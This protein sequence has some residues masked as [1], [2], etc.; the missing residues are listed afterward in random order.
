MAFDKG[1]VFTGA[2]AR[3]SIQG[4]TIGYARNCSGRE[5]TQ[6]DRIKG[7]GKFRTLEHVPVDYDVSFTMGW[8]RLVGETLKK[9]GWFPKVGVSSEEHLTNIL[10]SGD[11]TVTIEDTKTNLVFMT[12]E[13]AVCTDRNFNIDAVGSVMENTN[14]LGV[15]M[16]DESDD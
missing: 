13:Q 9:N 5:A 2:R 3:L 10:A 11:L 1:R 15:I 12:L 16:R 8:T 4:I 7:L 6:Y 14:W